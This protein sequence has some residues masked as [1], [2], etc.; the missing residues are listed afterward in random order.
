MSS[1]NTYNESNLHQT[2]KN[3]YSMEF[4]GKTEQKFGRFICDIITN[5]EIIEIQ[6]SNISALK[7]KIKFCI[8]N[9]RPIRIIHPLIEEKTIITLSQTGEL[10]TKRKSP[11]KQSI[12]SVL[13]GLTGIYDYL[14][15]D[16]FTLEIIYINAEEI[17][18]KTESPVQT[19][20]KS[21]RFLKNYINSEKKLVSINR[22]QIFK[23][24]TDYLKLL[25][26]G[27]PEIFTPPLLLS[28]LLTAEWPDNFTKSNIKSECKNY[29]LL[30]WLLEKMNLIKKTEKCGRSWLYKIIQMD[31]QSS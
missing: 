31:T 15:N 2:L 7:E 22:K 8:E 10:I 26:A 20:N 24:K 29:R 27:M 9:N 12:Y 17:H 25:P 6:T 11:R 5:K 1:I 23:T 14:T 16:L 13:K 4:S 18:I 3:I 30:L 28:N 19:Q 21:R